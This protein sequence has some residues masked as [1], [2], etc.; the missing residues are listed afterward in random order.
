MESGRKPGR[1]T[2]A[3]VLALPEEHRLETISG[4]AEEKAAP[5][6]GHSLAQNQLGGLIGQ[7]FGRQGG[8]RPGGWWILTEVDLE[9]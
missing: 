6:S 1:L 5:S 2:S 3:Q 8:G 4:I 7:S 9:F